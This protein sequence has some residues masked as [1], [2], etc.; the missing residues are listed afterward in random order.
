MEIDFRRRGMIGGLYITFPGEG[1]STC[2]GVPEHDEAF[3]PAMTCEKERSA[4][5]HNVFHS[6]RLRR[7]EEAADF[8]LL[9]LRQPIRVPQARSRSSI[10]WGSRRAG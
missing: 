3:A 4:P 10:D 5:V 8:K 7:I 6:S 9:K 2:A 1:A